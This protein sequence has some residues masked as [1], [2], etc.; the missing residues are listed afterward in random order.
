MIVLQIFLISVS[1]IPRCMYKIWY[2][3]GKKYKIE[4]WLTILIR[5]ISFSFSAK[6]R[7]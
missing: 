3:K 7:T 2:I 4:I 6:Y 1:N 5:Q